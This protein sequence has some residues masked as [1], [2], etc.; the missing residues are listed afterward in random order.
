MYFLAQFSKL[1]PILFVLKT[2]ETFLLPLDWLEFFSLILKS[3]K[4]DF[5]FVL[6][7]F[8]EGVDAYIK[9]TEP[10]LTLK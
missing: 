1:F 7:M 4:R 5:A 6:N 10:E 8:V 9:C 2:T 3:R